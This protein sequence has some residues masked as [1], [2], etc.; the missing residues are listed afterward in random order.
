MSQTILINEK[1]SK[2]TSGEEKAMR[3][4]GIDRVTEEGVSN[5]GVS[6][7]GISNNG[8]RQSVRPPQR[9]RHSS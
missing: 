8:V 5:N 4:D 2:I 6:N 1:L 7:N 9:R 3:C